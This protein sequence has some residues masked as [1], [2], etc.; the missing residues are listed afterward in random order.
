MS[1]LININTFNMFKAKELSIIKA[2]ERVN[3]KLA[4]FSENSKTIS[5]KDS[6][7]W[8]NWH[9]LNRR[10]KDRY[11]INYANFCEWH[12]KTFGFN[13]YSL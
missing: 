9:D 4:Y 1:E 7:N 6:E 3:S 2:H 11:N 5:K 13:V 12:F 8:N 10:L